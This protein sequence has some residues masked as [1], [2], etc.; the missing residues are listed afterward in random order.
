MKKINEDGEAEYGIHECYYDS[1]GQKVVAA[2]QNSIRPYGETP[3]ELTRDLERMTLAL[4]QPVV[5]FDRV[6]E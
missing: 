6:G 1:T 3:E 5:D 4:T 2:T